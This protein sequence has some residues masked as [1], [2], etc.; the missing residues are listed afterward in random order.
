MR[1]ND[2]Y[3]NVGGRFPGKVMM[4]LSVKHGIFTKF[5]MILNIFHVRYVPFFFNTLTIRSQPPDLKFVINFY[6]MST[7][8]ESPLRP[9]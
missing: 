2:H 8:N 9:R 4:R 1:H 7:I 5:K 3:G 6:Y